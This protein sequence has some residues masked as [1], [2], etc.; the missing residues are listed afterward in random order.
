MALTGKMEVTDNGAANYKIDIATPPGT[1]GLAPELSLRY[2]SHAGNGLLGMGW[3]LAGIPSIGRCPRTAA[4]DGVLGRVNYD[5]NDRFCLDGQRLIA[6]AGTDGSDGTEYRTELETFT[7]V[8]SRGVAGS[9]PA[10]FEIRTK[11]GRV[12]ELGRS[13]DSR[14]LASGKPT[15]HIWAANR[16]QDT[17]GNYISITYS[18][19][20]ANTQLYPARI[21]YVG[22]VAANLQ[23][24]NSV[25]FSYEARPDVVPLYHAGSL[26]QVT[27]RLS[28]IRTYAGEQLTSDYRLVYGQGSTTGRSRLVSLTQCDGSGN[29]LPATSF[30]WQSG[31]LSQAVVSNV[32]G[33]DG[34]LSG[35]RSYIGDF[36]GDGL[37]DILWDSE[38]S[39]SF[40]STG[41]RTL[42]R[43]LGAGS[44]TTEGNF[45]GL[46]GAAIGYSPKVG[47]FNRDGKADLAW[48]NPTTYGVV[49]WISAANGW[50]QTSE[51]GSPAEL[52]NDILPAPANAD[53]RDDVWWIEHWVLPFYGPNNV[54][55]IT[56]WKTYF[57]L[58]A[59]GGVAS[60]T[61]SMLD[62]EQY[63]V[64]ENG[65]VANGASQYYGDF[66]GDGALDVLFH[67]E[68]GHPSTYWKMDPSGSGSYQPFSSHFNVFLNNGDGTLGGQLSSEIPYSTIYYSAYLDRKPLFLDL[69]GDGKTD[70]IWDQVDAPWNLGADLPPGRSTGVRTVWL[71]KGD[72]TFA[73]IDNPGGTNGTLA[74]YRPLAGDF[75]GDG[76]MDVLWFQCDT[77]FVSTGP[78][79]LWRSK[80]DGTFAVIANFGGQDGA[81]IGYVPTVADFNGDGKADVFWDSRASGDS[82]SAGVRLLWLSDGSAPDLM[83]GMDNG[84]GASASATYKPLTDSTVHT[85]E[86]SV[87]DPVIGFSGPMQVVSRLSMSNGI[88]G[89]VSSAFTYVGA[90]IDLDGR[91][92]LGFRMK[93]VTD[94]QT[95]GIHSTTYR[96]D[97]PFVGQ[98]GSDTLSLNGVTLSSVTSDYSSVALGLTRYNVNL[99]QKIETGADLDGTTL[100]TT[101]SNYQ[102]DAYGNVTSLAQSSTDGF[103]RT[104]VNTYTNDESLW[105]LGRLT[106]AT[107]TSRKTQ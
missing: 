95:G 5:S 77:D 40:N 20:G 61:K 50:L 86:A 13:A 66:D 85:R 2:S 98:I 34:T 58:A 15:G 91:G 26:M 67:I 52:S 49:Q 100:P 72:G 69:N 78:R 64:V 107:V 83:T 51:L 24:Y 47:D 45:A 60:N 36:N 16:I 82:R 29:C 57:S 54:I 89:V 6:I 99:S 55:L 70:I 31:T 42:W 96:Q 56:K 23:P 22:N 35:S 11:S 39:T 87:V 37:P 65:P 8:V 106:R 48:L 88:G 3:E 105:Y 27:Q 7:K 104:T 97:Y 44:F 19:D 1:A 53:G 38:E 103:S 9:G 33:Q 68:Q 10:W 4:Q 12:I 43:N 79:V 46:N 94:L 71:S 59:A 76:K 21:D 80:G 75:D 28:A 90:K 63:Q 102:Y 18:N 92:F 84:I 17:A 81:A 62:I 41:A 30:T 101:T 74:G 25:R 73:V 14:L 93:N 32:A